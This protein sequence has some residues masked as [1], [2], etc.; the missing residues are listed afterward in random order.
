MT[1]ASI[2]FRAIRPFAPRERE[3]LELLLE[4]MSSKEIAYRLELAPRTIDRRV[5][6]MC[7][8][9]G[10]WTRR[11]LVIWALRGQSQQAA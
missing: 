3:I 11:E 2:K 9:A 7:D 1:K 6:G 5:E 4:G 8:K 10:V